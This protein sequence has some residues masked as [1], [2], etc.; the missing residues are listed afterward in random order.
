SLVASQDFSLL[1]TILDWSKERAD[2]VVR[3]NA[4]TIEEIKTAASFGA[5]GIG[6]AR[7]EHMFFGES[8]I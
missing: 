1:Q 4:E 5:A 2:L 8:R 3:A 6:L 7:T